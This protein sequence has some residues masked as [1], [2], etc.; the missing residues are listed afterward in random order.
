L[1]GTLPDPRPR[2][3]E[4]TAELR[5][6]CAL[7]EAADAPEPQQ[8]A[9]LLDL[10][11]ALRLS[12]AP[13]ADALAVLDRAGRLA[14]DGG[15]HPR[16]LA[17]LARAHTAARS[18]EEA[19]EA[20]GAA[21]DLTDAYGAPRRELLAEWGESLLEQAR[22]EPGS[23]ALERAEP[24]LRE[25]FSVSPGRAPGRARVQLLL[26]RAL[27]LRF[28]RQGF[29]PDL[30]EGV[31]LLEQ[32]ARHAPDGPTRAEAW[33]ELGTARLTLHEQT[34]ASPFSSGA[35]FSRAAEEAAADAFATAA[36]EDRAPGG[37]VVRAR[38]LHRRAATLE[39]L[40]RP[41]R[42]LAVYREAAAEWAELT[43]RLADVPWPEVQAT[44]EAVT[45][46]AGG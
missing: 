43:A 9:A 12:G 29:L 33:L 46:L 14:D 13:P 26:G 25:A 17:E 24:V 42:A 27:V 28:D 16:R 23:A 35:A 7:L 37:S 45:R 32:A 6:A 2:A 15:P 1:A 8:G 34:S 22:R 5:A 30:Y 21:V 39:R 4:A 40:E 3:A 38:A 20:Y 18:W 36:E 41:R 10:A 11:A 31:H 44:R 19:D